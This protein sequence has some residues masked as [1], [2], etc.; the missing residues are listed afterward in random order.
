M[1]QNAYFISGFTHIAFTLQRRVC[2]CVFVESN[3]ERIMAEQIEEEEIQLS[4]DDI[5]EAFRLP[6]TVKKRKPA[7]AIP[8]KY[9][10]RTVIRVGSYN[11]LSFTKQK[12]SNPGV[13]EVIC[14]TILEHG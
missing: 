5:V 14:M 12:A 8:S 2:F 7:K 13:R 11:M 6:L 3:V 10:G 9:K 4:S 1:I